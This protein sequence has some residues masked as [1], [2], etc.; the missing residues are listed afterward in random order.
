MNLRFEAPN[1]VWAYW[2]C[3]GT[4]DIS[5]V[6][7]LGVGGLF[8]STSIP[9]AVGVKAQ[10]D[11]LVQEGTIRVEAEVRHLIPSNGLGLKFTAISDQDGPNL[12]A[13]LNRIRG[14]PHPVRPN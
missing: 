10:L 8:L 14:L 7:D 9:Q 5:R 2:R 11:F 1:G 12:V 3:G 6:S 13:L 4:E